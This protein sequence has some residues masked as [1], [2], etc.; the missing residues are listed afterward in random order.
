MVAPRGR[1][2]RPPS[3]DGC[4]AARPGA[5]GAA[6]VHR[7]RHRDGDAAAVGDGLFQVISQRYLKSSVALTSHVG[8]ASWAERLGD[9]MMTA[10]MLDRLL[11]KGI[12]CPIDGPSYRMRSHQARAETLRR[13]VAP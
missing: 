2:G 10:A 13:A 7:R 3:W 5:E 4:A 6:H 12:V 8:I 9:P 1:A 11:H